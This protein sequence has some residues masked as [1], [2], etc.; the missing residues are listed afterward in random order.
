MNYKYLK[1][2]AEYANQKQ[3]NVLNVQIQCRK[4]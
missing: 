4:S 3:L 1:S 2:N